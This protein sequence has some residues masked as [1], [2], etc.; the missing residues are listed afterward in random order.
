[1]LDVHGF[2]D[3]DWVRDLDH[4]RSTCG[5]VFNLVGG[6]ISWMSKK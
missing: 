1:M 4:K 5:Y 6:A 3:H 2:V